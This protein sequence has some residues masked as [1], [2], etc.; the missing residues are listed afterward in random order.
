MDKEITEKE[1]L[2][3][4]FKGQLIWDSCDDI[5]NEEKYKIVCS[6]LK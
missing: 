1:H 2:R 5:L 6:Q 3:I 4:I